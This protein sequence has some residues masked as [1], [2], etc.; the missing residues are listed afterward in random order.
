MIKAFYTAASGMVA[1]SLKQDVIA[2][3]IANA[4]TA[5]FKKE[6]LVYSSFADELQSRM[7]R[8]SDDSS[9]AYSGTSVSGVKV[10]AEEAVDNTEG[11]ITPTGNN[12][13]FAIDGPG[14]F[15]LKTAKGT[16][17]TRQGNF[18]VNAKNQLCS[19]DGSLVQGEKGAITIPS[20]NWSVGQDGTI[21][22][23]GSVVDTIKVIGSQKNKTQ[24]LQGKLEG[25]NVS[26]VG[27]MVDMITN[28]RAFETNQKVITSVDQTLDKLINE[29]GKV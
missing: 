3:N 16:K 14:E 9:S 28:M 29:A 17:L 13:D 6:R 21:N 19:S 5:G 7:A 8:V 11:S 25:S 27:E 1:Q 22:V 4:Q 26:V 24:V 12:L 23:D 2:N 10:K 20:G 18:M 15:V